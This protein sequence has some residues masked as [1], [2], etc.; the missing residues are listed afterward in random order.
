M[1]N[2]LGIDH[3]L[4]AVRDLDLAI[5]RF[6]A[7][8]FT[9]APKSRHPWGTSTCI[10][11][12]QQ[13]LIEI[14]SI[15]DEA[16]LD[17]LPA[18][19]FHFGRHVHHYLQEREGIALTA[20]YSD[21]AE[22]DAAKIAAQGIT[23]QGT[24]RFGRD[25]VLPDGTPDRTATTL[26]ILYDADLPRLSNFI[27]QQHRPDLIYVPK[28]SNHANGATSYAQ[29]TIMAEL[30]DQPRVQ[31]RLTG[32]YGEQ[33]LQSLADGFAVKTGNGWYV[34]TD[35]AGIEKRY[36]ALPDALEQETQPACV[37]LHIN[38]PDLNTIAA[39]LE[40]NDIRD[41]G[42]D[43]RLHLRDASLYGNVFVNFTI[44]EAPY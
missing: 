39:L 4:I 17:E 32:L 15:Y 8:G 22:N 42:S 21:D 23:C 14:V 40:K 12:M 2:F 6:S 29:L 9:M 7:L 13:S 25:V 30:A 11:I 3:P 43:K 18:G 16:L 20:L 33:S 19:D 36:G 44:D 38:V 34:V 10:S 27:C 35:R 41:S 37:A 5:A 31:A 26:K 1:S 24:I 28:W